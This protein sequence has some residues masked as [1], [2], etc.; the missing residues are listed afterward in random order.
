MTAMPALSSAQLISGANSAP[1]NLDAKIQEFVQQVTFQS[2]LKAISDVVERAARQG[3]LNLVPQI[4]YTAI[5]QI[6]IE[7]NKQESIRNVLVKAYEANFEEAKKQFEQGVSP[8]TIQQDIIARSERM[9]K[10]ILTDQVFQYVLEGVLRQAMIQQQ[11]IL[12]MTTVAAQQAQYAAIVQQQQMM[13]RIAQEQYQQAL[14]S[15]LIR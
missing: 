14:S 12:V 7:G 9:M 11:K 15:A 4:A 6:A 5:Q 3:Q 2:Y 8:A 10:P 1:G 13:Q